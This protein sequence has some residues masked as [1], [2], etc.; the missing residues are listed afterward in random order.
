MGHYSPSHERFRSRGDRDVTRGRAWGIPALLLTTACG[1]A[2]AGEPEI[3]DSELGACLSQRALP[4]VARVT[5]PEGT[6]VYARVVADRQGEPSEVVTVGNATEPLKEIFDR[7]ASAN[8]E[9]FAIPNE[10]LAARVCSPVDLPQTAI[11]G[12]SRV[13][14][15]AGLNYA[16]H[17]EEAGGGDVFVFPKP[18]APT[19]AYTTVHAPDGIVLLDY[20]IELGF[21]FLDDVDPLDPPQVDALLAATAFFVS[22][23][24]SDREAIIRNANLTGPGTG[25]V[26]GKGQ[27]GFLPAG[28]WMVRGT[29][30]FAA[31]ES[32]GADGLALE[33][34]VDEGEGPVARQSSSTALMILDPRALIARIGEQIRDTGIRTPMPT[35]GNGGERFYPLAVDADAPRIP[36]GSVLLTGTPGGVALKAPSIAGVTLRGIANLRSPLTQFI[37][38]ETARIEQG[39]SYLKAGDQVVARIDGLGTQRFA[40]G[41]AGGAAPPDPCADRPDRPE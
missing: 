27:P 31:L 24:V 5:D 16:E 33:L 2:H 28:P 20:E 18:S 40:I 21:V 12:E 37:A 17:A 7:A 38:E 1:L 6:V 41:A 14:V 25:F 8:Q 30:L 22:N 11:D 3:P 23:D 35:T 19:G 36:A 9:P 13:V 34:W 32:C 4:R 39:G 26:T 15:A 29:E 10:Q